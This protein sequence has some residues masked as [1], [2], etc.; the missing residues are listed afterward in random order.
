MPGTRFTLG[1]G[2]H[3]FAK[4]QGVDGRDEP[5]HDGNSVNPS[6]FS[7]ARRRRNR[8]MRILVSLALA[9]TL[10]HG[11]LAQLVP[12]PAPPLS[13]QLQPE[14]QAEPPLAQP[15]PGLTIGPALPP[16]PSPEATT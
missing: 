11:A 10:C 12:P 9:V 2:I 1:P 16:P 7:P 13:E 6:L 15:G 8:G 5:G 4:K 3:V 14:H